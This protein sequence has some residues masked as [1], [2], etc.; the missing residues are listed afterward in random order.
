[1]CAQQDLLAKLPQGITVF[2]PGNGSGISLAVPA[3]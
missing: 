2:A 1:V 3:K